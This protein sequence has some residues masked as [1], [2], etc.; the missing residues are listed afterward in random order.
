MMW[1]DI[2]YGVAGAFALLGCF[3]LGTVAGKKLCYELMLRDLE[4]QAGARFLE[5]H[6]LHMQYPLMQFRSTTTTENRKEEN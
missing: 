5:L 1:S 2:A 6:R 4:R 3:L